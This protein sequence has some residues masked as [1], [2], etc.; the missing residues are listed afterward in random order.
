MFSNV[1][2]SYF[3]VAAEKRRPLQEAL[4]KPEIKGVFRGA[5][6]LHVLGSRCSNGETTVMVFCLILGAFSVV[7]LSMNNADS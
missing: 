3:L 2:Y 6:E 5:G 4:R 7:P 1:N